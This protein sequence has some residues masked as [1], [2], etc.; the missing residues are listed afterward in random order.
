M[1]DLTRF[2]H[3]V[4]PAKQLRGKP[5]AVTI[6]GRKYALWRDAAGRPCAVVDACPHRNASL[7][8]GRVR[9]DGRLACGYHGWHFDGE[10]QG[11][12][13]SQPKLKCETRSLQVVE[14][15]GYLW[16][17]SRQTPLSALP[18][19]GADGY[20][21]A[22]AFPTEF[23]AP[24]HITLDN[25]TEDEHFPYVHQ[26][27]GWDEAHWPEVRYDAATHDDRT[28]A[29]YIGPQRS[30]PV[31]PLIG[32]KVGDLFHNRFETRFDPVRTVY[33][34]HWTTP[35]E[36]ERRPIEARTVVFMLPE[37]ETTTRFHTFVF[38]RVSDASL[39]SRLRPVIKLV[40]RAFVMAEWWMDA[41]WVRHMADVAK[42][43]DGLRLGKFDKTVIRNR[44]LLKSL[45]LGEDRAPALGDARP[46]N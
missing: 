42:T 30:A 7:S 38:V 36:K 33:T 15:H 20:E 26:W 12:S 25:F 5:V 24:I 17:A 44:K 34:S 8:R 28:E 19:I 23:R 6:A 1:D 37:S 18:E 29:Q 4:L 22:G 14:R 31:L 3:P 40:A 16:M 46:A 35:D 27:F 45:Y 9:V 41:R 10:G 32:V 13:P 43:L 21:L 11:C 2:F 39:F